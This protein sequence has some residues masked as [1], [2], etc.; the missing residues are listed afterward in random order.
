MGAGWPGG[1]PVVLGVGSEKAAS[2][3][4]G[5]GEGSV[6]RVSRGVVVSFG[7][8]GEGLEGAGVFD[9]AEGVGAVAVGLVLDPV[10]GPLVE[11]LAVPEGGGGE[12]VAAED[13]GGTVGGGLFVLHAAFFDLRSVGER[14][15]FGGCEGPVDQ[16]GG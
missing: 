6:R 3:P 5:G 16:G 2:G 13:E 9:A 14:R 10:T 7:E 11:Q 12:I 1:G 4:R 15:C 8:P